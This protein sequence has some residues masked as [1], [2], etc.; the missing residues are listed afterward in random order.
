QISEDWILIHDDIEDDSLQRRGKPTLH[1]IYGKE[2]AINAGDALHILM[3]QVLKDN[4]KLAGEGIGQKIFDEFTTMLSR[5]VFGQTVEIK[6]TQ[7]NKQNLSDQDILLILESKTAYYTI[8]GPMRLGAI[9]AG[10]NPKQLNSIYQFAKPLGYCFQI[11]DDLLDLTSDFQGQK[12]QTGNDIYEGKR[13]IMLVHLLR[14]ANHKDKEK[15]KKILSKNR[16]QKTKTEVAWTINMM[17][18]YGSL[19]YGEKL[20]A[21][22]ALQ[23]KQLFDKNLGFLSKQPARDQLLAG[24]EFVLNRKH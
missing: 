14:T 6:W 21:K 20:A 12:K 3:W 19:N 2:L 15:L 11:R 4:L 5:T 18:K 22:F 9:L 24:I 17:K 13:T 23:A 10:A 16:Q 1:Q 7:E 8:A